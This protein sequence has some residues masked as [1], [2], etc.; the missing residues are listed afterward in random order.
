VRGR[1]DSHAL[2]LARVLLVDDRQDAERNDLDELVAA[3][4]IDPQL[5][6]YLEQQ[7]KGTAA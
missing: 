1:L 4:P 7:A 2:Y 5:Q 6:V 3:L